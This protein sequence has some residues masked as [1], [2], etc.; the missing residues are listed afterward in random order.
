[1][2]NV[3]HQWQV[4]S[5]ISVIHTSRVAHGEDLSL[6]GMVFLHRCSATVAAEAVLGLDVHPDQ[7]KPYSSGIVS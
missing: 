5:A 3:I 7:A 4:Y 6:A 2:T 1:M